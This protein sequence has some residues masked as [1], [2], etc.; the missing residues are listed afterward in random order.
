ML[1]SYKRRSNDAVFVFFN[2]LMKTNI[3]KTEAKEKISKF[4]QSN[5]FTP[6]QLKKIKRISMKFN[7]KLGDYRK[8]F[9]RKCL[10]SLAGKLSISKTHKT[11]ICGHCGYKNKIRISG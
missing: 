11:I 5:D 10:N 7:I 6:E 9:C 4:F 3:T 1:V 8:L 2:A